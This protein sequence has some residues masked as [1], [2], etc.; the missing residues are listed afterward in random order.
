MQAKAEQNYTKRSAFAYT[1]LMVLIYR[2]VLD[3]AFKTAVSPIYDYLGFVIN[4]NN[5]KLI[6]SYV[7]LVV[8]YVLMPRLI[9]SVS[10]ILLWLLIFISYIPM[11]TIYAFEDKSRLFMYSVSLFWIFVIIMTKVPTP[12]LKCIKHSKLIIMLLCMSAIA[13]MYLL[14][15]KYVGFKFNLNLER[16]YDVREEF[17][18]SGIPFGAYLFSWI[19]YAINPILFSL[20]WAKKKWALVIVVSITQ[21]FAFTA[22]GNKTFLFALPYVLFLKWSAKRDSPI[23]YILFGLLSVIMA[24]LLSYRLYNDVWITHLI[25][26]RMLFLPAQISFLYYEFFSSNDF[27]YLS[28]SIFQNIVPYGYHIGPT[29]LISEYFF[30]YSN[31][32]ANTGIVGDAYMNF[33]VTGLLLWGILLTIVLKLYDACSKNKDQAVTVAAIAMLS[34]TLSNSALL[35]CLLTHGV[36]VS[37][38]LL[39]L[40]PRTEKVIVQEMKC[41]FKIM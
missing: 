32:S 13:A 24:G 19:A 35:T 21:F 30:G 27:V 10:V 22:T 26:E 37:L 14:I 33:G 41:S 34:I 39:F 17:T 4:L 28:H 31:S 16:I 3:L 8:I 11:L 23:V 6:E 40:I 9:S 20:L 38:I 2:V 36:L 5:V 12:N 18:E 15:Y 1:L 25:A 29:Q 7:F